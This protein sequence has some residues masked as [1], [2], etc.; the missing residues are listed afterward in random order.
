MVDFIS[1]VQEELRKD[2]YNKWMKRYGPY[3]VG[4][5][6]LVIAGAGYMEWDKA[7]TERLARA[8][9]ASYIAA[10]DLAAEG[11]TDAAIQSFLRLAEEAPAGYAGLSLMRAAELE[12]GAG[13]VQ[14]AVT[15]LDRAANTFATTRHQQLAQIKAA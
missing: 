11:R 3:V 6:V 15:L 5:I 1:E 7:Q 4:F 13:K 10:S 12:L 9:S 8:T 2:D 14:E